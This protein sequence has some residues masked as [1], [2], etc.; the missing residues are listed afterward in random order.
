M[1]IPS[2]IAVLIVLCILLGTFSYETSLLK[3]CRKGA[4][5]TEL[6]WGSE[7]IKCE[8]IE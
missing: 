6:M 4:D 1:N 5:E 8:V 2:L 7:K 3:E